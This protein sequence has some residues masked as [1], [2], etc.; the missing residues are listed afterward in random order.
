MSSWWVHR[1]FADK[2]GLDVELSRI[3]DEIIDFA[4]ILPDKYETPYGVFR[5]PRN[6]EKRHDWVKYYPIEA[7]WNSGY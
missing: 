1:H 4:H 5:F 6:V 3:V 7:L 2:L